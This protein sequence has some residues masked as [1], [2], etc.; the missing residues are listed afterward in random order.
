MTSMK[1]PTAP[2]IACVL[3]AATIALTPE[4]STAATFMLFPGDVYTSDSATGT[5]IQS[6]PDGS[7]LST[8]TLS[9]YSMGTKGLAFGPDDTLY[10]VA[11]TMYGY[12]VVHLGA[13]GNLL[14]SYPGSTYVSGNLSYGKIA[15][16]ASGRVYVAG[17]STL[18]SLVPGVSASTPIYTDNQVIDLDFLPSGNLLVLTAYRVVEL[19]PTGAFVREV[20]PSHSVVDGRGIKYERATD[21]FVTTM[22]GYTDHYYELR[23]WDAATGAFLG[24]NYYNYG[25]DIDLFPDGRLLIGSRTLPPGIFDRNLGMTNTF[26]ARQRM[27]V[28][29]HSN[30]IFGDGFGE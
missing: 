28:A 22:L 21:T 7:E 27:F 30:P 1:P 18:M 26:N 24:W 2:T 23:R 15:V 4:P 5:V 25:D 6:A 14:G 29:I 10:V 16:A 12:D 17:Q 9:G 8:L 20:L 3:C 13:G 11:A 19:T